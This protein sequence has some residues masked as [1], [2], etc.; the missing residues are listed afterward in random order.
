MLES[1]TYLLSD[2]LFIYATKFVP[3]IVYI[4]LYSIF[5]IILLLHQFVLDNHLML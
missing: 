4:L 5:S 3:Q 2:I 1:C